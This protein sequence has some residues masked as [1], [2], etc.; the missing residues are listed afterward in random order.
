[1]PQATYFNCTLLFSKM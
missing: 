1:M